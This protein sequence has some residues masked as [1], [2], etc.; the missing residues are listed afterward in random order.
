MSFSSEEKKLI[1][2][3]SFYFFAVA[4][5]DIFVTVFFF[6]HGTFQ[7]PVLY[8]IIRI[9]VFLGIFI[10]SGLIFNKVRSGTIIKIGLFIF[11]VFY[12]FLFLLKERSITYIIPL[13]VLNGVAM[14]CFWSG[15]NLN[16]YIY[17]NQK[18]RIS[19]FGSSLIAIQ[20][21]QSIAPFLGGAIIT[22]TSSRYSLRVGY[23]VLFLAVSVI[24]ALIIF[25]VGKLPDHERLTFS[26]SHIFS[27]RRTLVWKKI[28]LQQFFL[29][30]FDMPGN[31]I[32]GILI[33][34][35]IKKEFLLGITQTASVLISILGTLLA[36]RL[37][38]KSS[39]FYW[40]GIVG[41]SLGYFVF[42]LFQSPKG[43]LLYII[44]IGLTSP[45]MNTWV[46]TVYYRAMDSVS[47]HW[48][49]K[50]HLLFERDVSL[51]F[52]RLFSYTLIFL[53]IHP[54]NQITLARYAVFLLPI[55]P[56]LLGFALREE[57]TKKL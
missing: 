23:G 33:Y 14:G 49:E 46:P 39:R 36:I 54:S 2:I 25:L 8:Q 51:A 29:G 3:Q 53:F 50:Y 10:L 13:S 44:L 40:I 26:I 38:H 24:I 1:L 48:K 32:V 43:V 28:L 22:T 52:G 27:H 57:K 11:A 56:L 9:W 19:F 30:M 34:L 42:G 41:I 15:Y 20:L 18:K 12:F 35:V 31:T 21:F 6:S 16:Q 17:S 5:A 55:P 47:G 45:F 4:L 7:T 37:L